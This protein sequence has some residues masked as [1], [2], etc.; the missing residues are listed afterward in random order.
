MSFFRHLFARL[1]HTF[2]YFL[3][4]CSLLSDV[5]FVLSMMCLTTH[6]YVCDQDASFEYVILL[7]LVFPT[8]CAVRPTS[9]TTRFVP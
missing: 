5:Q 7:H 2:I 3:Y 6:C 9:L 4:V 8:G 1:A